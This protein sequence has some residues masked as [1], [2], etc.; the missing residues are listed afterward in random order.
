L[1]VN[2][3]LQ[4]ILRCPIQKVG[5]REMTLR[6][7]Q[8]VNRRIAMGDLFHFDGTLIGQKIESGFISEDGKLGYPIVEGVVI[9]LA[10]LA[11]VLNNNIN[12]EGLNIFLQKEKKD[13]KDLYDQILWRKEDEDHFVDALKFEDLRKVSKEYIH[14]CHIRINRY[15][16]H[17]GNYILDV[18]SGP[19]QYPEY[20]TYSLHFKVRICVDISF[21]A[22]REARRKLGEKGVY[23]LADITNLPL[24]D[25]LMDSVVSLHTIYHVPKGEQI[26]AFSEIYRVLKI[27][28]PAIVVYRG[29]RLP[30]TDLGLSFFRWV[31]TFIRKAL[32]MKQS[33]LKPLPSKQNTTLQKHSES[34]WS[35]PY[36]YAYKYKFL[37]KQDWG[38]NLEVCVWRSV[39]V[40]FLK[41]FIHKW[42]F[43]KQVLSIIFLLEE[44]FPHWVGRIG[45]YPLFL[46]K[47]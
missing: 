5:L 1:L 15:L 6:E 31:K 39:S 3:H 4:N 42:F 16:R 29:A 7:V 17:E 36:F 14:K 18:A 24:K 41:I 34:S 46:L 45:Y 2:K 8:E 13:V 27:G 47:K 25:D 9:L 43:G 33:I 28:S 38:K 37:K 35:N 44:K 20:L 26:K 22:L 40:E 12:N 11:M 30:L 10:S 32:D 23:L 19:V 21:V